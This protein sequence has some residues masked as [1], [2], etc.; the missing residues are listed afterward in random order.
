MSWQSAF[1]F[2]NDRFLICFF[3]AEREP[4]YCWRMFYIDKTHMNGYD[5]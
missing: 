5:S 4:F 1:P 2:I 3:L